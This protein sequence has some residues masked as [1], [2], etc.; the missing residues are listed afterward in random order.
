MQ[1]KEEMNNGKQTIGGLNMKIEKL[2]EKYKVYCIIN[3]V[4]EHEQG[5]KGYV[6]DQRMLERFR[7]PNK[8][9]TKMEG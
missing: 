3:N 2:R 1:N 8:K 6:S 5:F 7:K 4:V 9:M